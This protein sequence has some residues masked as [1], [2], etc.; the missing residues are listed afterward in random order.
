MV[1]ARRIEGSIVVRIPKE[2]V[3]EEQISEGKLVEVEVRKATRDWF[4]AFPSLKAFSREEE[5]DI[6]G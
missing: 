2:L 4:G 5:L 1:K 6:D 3:D